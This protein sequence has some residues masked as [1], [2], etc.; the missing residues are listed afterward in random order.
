MKIEVTDEQLALLARMGDKKAMDLLLNKYKP[1]V[2]GKVKR[3]FVQGATRED[4][5]QEG[6]I[7]LFNAVMNYRPEKNDSFAAF[8]SMCI[9][10]RMI[11]VL[12][13]A[14]RQKNIPLNTSISLNDPVDCDG[15]TLGDTLENKDDGPEE[16]FLK[17]E[18]SKNTEKRLKGALSKFEFEVLD[19][20]LKGKNYK[21]IAEILGSDKK[22]VDNALQRIRRKIS[23]MGIE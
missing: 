20:F 22:S 9:R 12:E 8:A 1:F 17:K 3:Y 10:R 2:N 11:N 23:R 14:N 4:V 16:I 21:E 15:R 7:G 5:L 19:G 6:M 18:R 13:N